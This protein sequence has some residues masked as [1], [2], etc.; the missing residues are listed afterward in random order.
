MPVR[1]I[2]PGR[3]AITGRYPS[4]KTQSSHQFESSLERDFL[5]LLEFDE[6]V[7]TYEVQPVTIFYWHI[8]K[9][10]R[11]TPDIAVHYRECLNKKPIL[12]EIKYKA[13]LLIKSAY[14]EPKFKAATEYGI[15]NSFEFRIFTEEDIRTDYLKNVKFLSRYYH[16]SI[17]ESVSEIILTELRQDILSI[18]DLLTDRSIATNERILF[19]VWQMLAKRILLCEMHQQIKM[20]SK[21]WS[22]SEQLN[23]HT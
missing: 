14:Y 3:F 22:N 20:T 6:N 13:E 15:Q 5:T 4:I 12:C 9:Q 16:T 2:K 10:A 8:N 18:Q 23:S 1:K 19:T 17:D 7:R 21:I 11:Y